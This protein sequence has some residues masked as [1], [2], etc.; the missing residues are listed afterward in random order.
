MERIWRQKRLKVP[1]KQPKRD[2][3]WPNDDS[4]IRLRP[5]YRNHVWSYDF[6]QD[7]TQD[8]KPRGELLN[9]EIFLTLTEDKVQLKTRRCEYNPFKPHNALGYRPPAPEMIEPPL[10]RPVACLTQ[11]V[12][13]LVPGRSHIAGAM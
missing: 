1:T 9:R 5:E 12:V 8:G 2:R 6:V 7:R 10:L 3:I 11:R 13:Q 4:R